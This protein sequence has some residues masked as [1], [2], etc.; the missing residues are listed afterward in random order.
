M[1]LSM[2]VRLSV[3]HYSCNV[4][5][6]ITT[7]AW[8][9]VP[10]TVLSYF[11]CFPPPHLNLPLRISSCVIGGQSLCGEPVSEHQWRLPICPNI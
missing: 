11:P 6:V 8:I 2:S 3:E 4:E 9:I 7:I 1:L 5:T 10:H